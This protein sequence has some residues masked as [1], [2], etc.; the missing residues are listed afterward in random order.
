MFFTFVIV[1]CLAVMLGKFE[2]RRG[3]SGRPVNGQR[4]ETGSGSRR[5]HQQ[6][7]LFLPCVQ[8]KGVLGVLIAMMRRTDT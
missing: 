2:R 6:S 8:S 1:L 4:G 7:S 5:Q 3:P